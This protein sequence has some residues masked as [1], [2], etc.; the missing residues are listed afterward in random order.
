MDELSKIIRVLKKI[1]ESI[2]T[3][4]V[5]VLDGNI[6]QNSIKQ[7][8]VFKEICNIDS[9]VVTK[10]DGSAKGGAIVPIAEKL[11]IP[12]SFIG[13]GEAKEDLTRFNADQFCSA[14][15]DID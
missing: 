14:L 6:G 15:L 2:P 13:T 9:L 11:K 4:I 3:E 12:I 8:E 10:L 1:D 5:L 7:A